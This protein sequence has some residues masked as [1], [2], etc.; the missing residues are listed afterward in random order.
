MEQYSSG[1]SLYCI[2]INKV[3]SGER[4]CARMNG[5]GCWEQKTEQERET[6]RYLTNEA[7]PPQLAALLGQSLV[8]GI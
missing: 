8:P 7:G 4:G 3:L 2:Q 1:L 6:E 5:E